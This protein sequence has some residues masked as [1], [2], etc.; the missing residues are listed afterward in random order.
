MIACLSKR[1]KSANSEQIITILIFLIIIT[2]TVHIIIIIVIIIVVIILIRITIIS[3]VTSNRGKLKEQNCVMNGA[4]FQVSYAS[5][6]TP[7]TGQDDIRKRDSSQH[8]NF[9]A[10]SSLS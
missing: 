4:S 9:L 10:E 6:S 2:A 7:V 1:R 5:K 8:M 3:I